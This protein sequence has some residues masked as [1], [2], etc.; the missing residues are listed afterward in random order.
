MSK[1]KGLIKLFKGLLFLAMIFFIGGFSGIIGNRFIMP[2]LSSFDSFQNS[3][4]FQEANK[5]TTII[6]K[7]E[8][9]VVEEDYSVAK[10]AQ[11][12]LPSVVSVV[13]F[14]QSESGNKSTIKS[15]QDIQKNIKTGLILTGDG[16]IVSVLD[17]ITKEYLN[18]AQQGVATPQEINFKVLTNN[19]SEYDARI[20]AIDEYSQ[21]VY[22]KIEQDNL[23]VPE[24]G[25][26]NELELGEKIIICGNVGGQNQN[27]FSSGII[28]EKDYTFSLL[29][30]ELSSS[31]K[32]EGAIMVDAQIEPRN[33]GG[34]AVD[35]NG[36]VVGIANIIEKDGQQ[37]GFVMPI[38]SIQKSI[39]RVVQGEVIERP[40]LGL[41]YLSINREIALLNNLPVNQGALVYSF[42]GQQGLA[43]IKNSPADQTGIQINDII[44][45]VDGQM[46]NLQN[47]LANLIAR[48]KKGEEV[49]LDL[50]RDGEK[51]KVEVILD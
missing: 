5:K 48:K 36:N 18:Q 12:V 26:S 45:S 30:S 35:F 37:R 51:M 24:F 23:T 4:F 20:Y 27:T 16:L 32:M 33:V 40:E 22:Y 15:S 31:E 19:G 47:P 3:K 2:W 11:R 38:D 39:N 6:N 29:N 25:N 9:V 49:V 46:V 8:R 21:L 41:Y 10:T 1:K 28:K 13:S 14:P 44:T 50:M 42:S 43:V 17:K 34:P 7:T